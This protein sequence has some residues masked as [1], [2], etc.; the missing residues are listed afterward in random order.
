MA[1]GVDLCAALPST[2]HP[3]LLLRYM[4]LG[5]HRRRRRSG[6]ARIQI[7]LDAETAEHPR[8]RIPFVVLVL[9]PFP[10]NQVE[11]IGIDHLTPSE[12]DLLRTYS[13]KLA[14]PRSTHMQR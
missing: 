3:V 13:M 5:G 10:A 8:R 6:T 4:P 11:L 1:W 2:A 7:E 9:D 14:D 12:V